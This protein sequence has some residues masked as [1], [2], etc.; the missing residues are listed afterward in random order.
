M[1]LQPR[2]TCRIDSEVAWPGEIFYSTISIAEL[3]VTEDEY[4]KVNVLE[5]S[6]VK[7]RINVTQLVLGG[8][9]VTNDCL[10]LLEVRVR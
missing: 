3:F 4:D 7:M 10:G 1:G 2:K 5:F 9:K 8:G 6:V